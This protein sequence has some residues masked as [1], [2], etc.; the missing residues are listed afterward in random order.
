MAGA[1]ARHE[2]VR[3]DESDDP[4]TPIRRT[5]AALL[6]TAEVAQFLAV[7]E[8]TVKRLIARRRLPCVR[9]GRS[10]R[11]QRQAV[12]RWLEARQEGG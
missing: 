6:T 11:F 10:V 8:R 4:A 1:R 7:S 9:I 5:P 2:E 3:P 12:F